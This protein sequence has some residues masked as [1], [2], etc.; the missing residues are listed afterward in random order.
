MVASVSLRRQIATDKIVLLRSHSPLRRCVT[1]NA[2]LTLR[3]L[4]DGHAKILK[5]ARDYSND[6]VLVYFFGSHQL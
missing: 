3:L 5:K 1:L 2:V 4:G 6:Y